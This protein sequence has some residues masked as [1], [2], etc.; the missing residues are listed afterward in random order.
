MSFEDYINTKDIVQE[1]TVSVA[2]LG[3]LLFSPVSMPI[4]IYIKQQFP[5]LKSTA[6][7]LS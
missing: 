1:K 4:G 2:V 7:L 5:L 6:V 3:H